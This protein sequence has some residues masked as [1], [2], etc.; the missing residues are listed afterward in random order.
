MV[1]SS[2]ENIIAIIPGANGRAGIEDAEAAIAAMQTGDHLL[3]QLEVPAAATRAA[4]TAARRAGITSVINTAPLTEDAAE[5]AA[6][7]DIVVANE[8][9]FKLLAGKS[10]TAAVDREAEL[11]RL[12][13]DSGQTLIVT[14][15][16]DGVIAAREGA[17]VRVNGLTILPVDTVGAGDTFLR[18][19]GGR[20][21]CRPGFRNRF[22][23]RRSRR[24]PRLS[25][26]RRPAGHP[27]G[28]RRRQGTRLIR[29]SPDAR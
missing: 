23:A 27:D 24:Q 6:L 17:L 4:M 3:L 25:Q 8:T 2:G 12:H 5:L 22:A 15:G 7:A 26:G 13:A 1:D 21:R 10:L 28:G 20:P 14:L 11:M 18:L 9:E 16:A 19:P 29:A